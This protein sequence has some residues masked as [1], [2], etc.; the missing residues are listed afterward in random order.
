MTRGHIKQKQL[1]ILLSRLLPHP[2]PKIKFETYTLDSKSA[3]QFLTIAG[4]IN[5]DIIDKTII[6]LGCGTGVLAIGAALIGAKFVVGVDIDKDGIQVAKKNTIK[7]G[8][9]VNYI[10]SDIKAI[11]DSFDTSLMNPPFGCWSRGADVQFLKKALE[12]SNVVYSLHKRSNKN[13]YF[14]KRKIGSLGG[15]VNQIYE[16]EIFLPHSFNFHK[17]KEYAVKT[18]L[19]RILSTEKKPCGSKD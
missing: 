7:T 11:R 10:I 16:L 9:D 15:G 3:S 8:V 5:N 13:R 6:D 12:I 18:D 4:Y 1:A 14:L 17:K 2:E 19:Y